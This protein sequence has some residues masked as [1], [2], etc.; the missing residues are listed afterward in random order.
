MKKLNPHPFRIETIR[1]KNLYAFACETSSDQAFQQVAP[2]SLIRAFAQAKNPQGDPEDAALMV[3]YDNR[4]CVGYHGVL[5]GFLSHNQTMSKVYWLVT[6]FLNPQ[7]RGRGLGK[8]LVEEIQK[9]NGDLVTTGIT[10]AAENVYRS[11]GFKELGY[12]SYFQLRMDKLIFQTTKRIYYALLLFFLKSAKKEF[13][14]KRVEQLS[15]E[16]G[17]SRGR[18]SKRPVFLRDIRTINWMLQHRWVVSQHQAHPDVE[19][20]YFSRLRDRFE[21]IALEIY[22]IDEKSRKGY[23]VLSVSTKKDKTIIKILDLFF[24]ETKDYH[25]AAYLGLKYAKAYLADCIEYPVCLNHFFSDQPFLK[26]LLKKKKRLYL[27]YPKGEDSPLAMNAPKIKLDY[28]DS[29]TA[30]T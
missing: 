14:S 22:T 30:F 24:D 18:H 19:N 5:P 4:H 29:D 10:A 20:Y 13:I 28:C 25:I 21:F 11:V 9:T 1:L 16:I 6:F 17:E 12:L 27:Y 8:L 23:L 7:Y 3:A 26:R 2:I 15:N